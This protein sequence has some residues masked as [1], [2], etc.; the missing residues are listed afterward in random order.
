MLP[1]LARVAVPRTRT[2]EAAPATPA[3]PT[4]V[5]TAAPGPFDD[6]VAD[7]AEVTRNLAGVPRPDV[8]AIPERAVALVA[9][10]G[11]YGD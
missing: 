7:C 8:V 10:L 6:M 4:D 2:P 11:R 3:A 5:L 1:S 9:D